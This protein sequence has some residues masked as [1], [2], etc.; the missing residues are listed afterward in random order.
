MPSV[1]KRIRVRGPTASSNRTWYPAVSPTRSPSSD[2]TRRAAR[3]AAI[4]RGSSTT[5]SPLPRPRIAGGTRVVFPA[6]GG[7]SM[8]RL[9]LSPRDATIRG[10]IASIGRIGLGLTQFILVRR[11]EIGTSGDRDIGT[12]GH[13]EIGTSGHRNIGKPENRDSCSD[14]PI[15]RCPDLPH[16]VMFI[17]MAA[18]HFDVLIMGAGLSG[19][20][21]AWH[22][23]K[24]C[25]Q[26]SYVITEQRERIGG[27]WDLFR[28]PGVRSDS[29]MLTIG[30][31][32]RPWTQPKAIS[33]VDDIRDYIA[34]TARDAG[35]DRNIRFGH[36]IKSAAWSSQDANWTL[37]AVR[38]SSA[39]VEE[40]VTLTCNFLF[41]CAGYYRYSSG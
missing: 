4:R 10:R 7:A 34:D 6:P 15:S 9:G 11:R 17:R 41:S 12:S 32:F 24:F 8:T 22:L 5:T 25:P 21:A 38:K 16:C 3:R 39:G 1:T 28:Y 19:I 36:Q 29:D 37:E 33:P 18:E 23:Q 35:I 2:A 26:K 40:A 31:S 20:D 27:T 14:L 13:R 30:Y